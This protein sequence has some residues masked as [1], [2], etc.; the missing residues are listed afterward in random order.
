MNLY[1]LSQDENDDYDTYDVMVVAAETE[2]EARN[3][4]PMNDRWG[5][6][7]CW[8]TKPENVTVRLIG[9]AA[10]GIKAGPILKSF[11]AG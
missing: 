2:D 9:T 3:I 5:E 10:E 11:N 4:L 8:A 1:L 7:D 6:S